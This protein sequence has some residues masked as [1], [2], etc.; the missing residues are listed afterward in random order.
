MG[1][2]RITA[3]FQAFK[4]NRCEFNQASSAS[5]FFVRDM[6]VSFIASGDF[7]L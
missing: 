5:K 2:G 4:M 7:S 6:N 1:V 3:K